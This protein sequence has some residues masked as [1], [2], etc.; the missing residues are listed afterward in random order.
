MT[1]VPRVALMAWLN[2][3]SSEWVVRRFHL[4]YLANRGFYFAPGT[5][6]ADHF[7][8]QRE[9]RS[10][11]YAL[12]DS[13]PLVYFAARDA[14][15]YRAYWSDVAQA[16]GLTK[17]TPSHVIIDY[18]IDSGFIDSWQEPKPISYR[19]AYFKH[20]GRLPL[21]N[22]GSSSYSTP[23]RTSASGGSATIN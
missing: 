22:P 19:D 6:A 20:F 14:L 9:A 4:R 21:L 2:P 23:S 7:Q 12:A 3:K 18:A 16:L 17:D 11:K 8:T 5:L 13:E 1:F 10:R 15:C